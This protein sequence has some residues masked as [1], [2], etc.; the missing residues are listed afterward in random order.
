RRPWS[1]RGVLAGWVTSH[2]REERHVAV[3]D[4][5]RDPDTGHGLPVAV[6]PVDGVLE[7]DTLDRE[8]LGERC[9]E[10]RG[11]ERR[12]SLCRSLEDMTGLVAQSRE[13]VGNLP[14]VGRRVVAQEP[15]ALRTRAWKPESREQHVFETRVIWAVPVALEVDRSVHSVGDKE[16]AGDAPL[17]ELG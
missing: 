7:R 4:H 15:C 10:A 16:G 3:A 1:L 14:P 13:A 2:A 9:V 6:P 17:P 12:S 5:L 11:R 8:A